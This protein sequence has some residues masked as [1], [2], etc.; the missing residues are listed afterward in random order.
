MRIGAADGGSVRCAFMEGASQYAVQAN[1]R[2]LQAISATD[3]WRG[4]ISDSGD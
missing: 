2:P 3:E 4:H 1:L